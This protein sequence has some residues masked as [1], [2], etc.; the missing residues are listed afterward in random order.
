MGAMGS[1]GSSLTLQL[2]PQAF[3]VIVPL[4]TIPPDCTFS[5]S[6]NTVRVGEIIVHRG[7]YSCF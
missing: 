6:V 2:V 3:V 4:R 5:I 7:R 1:L